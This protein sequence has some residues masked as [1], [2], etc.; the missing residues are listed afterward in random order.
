ML[1]QLALTA[2]LIA[3]GS[4]AGVAQENGPDTRRGDEMIAAY[5]RSETR[6]LAERCLAGIETLEDW[7]SRREEY[8]RQL[9]EMLGLDPMPERTDLKP[10]VT[11]KL[12]HEA[13]TVENLHFQSRPGLY[14]TGN[15]Y[16]P[17]GL[18]KPAPA[19][20]YVCGHAA[21]KKDGVSYGNKTH[22]QFHPAWF[23]RNGYVCLSID[24]IQLGEIEGLHH[25]TYREGMWWWNSRGY[26][27]AGVEA[28]N[29]IRALD[30]LESRPE[31]DA[32]RL[33]ITGRSGGGAYSWWVAALDDRIKA[34]V[35]V[36]GITDLENHV[37][38][39]CVEGHCDCMYMVNTYRWDYAQVAALVA[40]RPLLI[41]NTD[42]DPIF[43]LDG[44]QRIHQ[45]VREIY[46]LY[47]AGDKLGLQI[48]EGP[49]KD[50]QEL[51]VATFHWFNRFLKQ[52]DPPVEQTGLSFFQP[53]QLRVFGDGPPADEI[54]SRIH[55][56]F[57][58]AAA[59]P[60]E[61]PADA[62]SWAALRDAWMAALKEKCF[63]G[64]PEQPAELH[65]EQAFSVQREGIRLTAL[66]FTSQPEIRLRLYLAEPASGVEPSAVVLSVESDRGYSGEFAA[67]CDLFPEEMKEEG[68]GA[69]ALALDELRLQVDKAPMAFFAPRGQGRTRWNQDE[70]KQVQIRRR[71]MLLGQTL[72]AMQA[73]DIR[74]AIQAL[75]SLEQYR[76][77][78]VSIAAGEMPVQAL[79]ASLF[80]PRVAA[81]DFGTL[82][83]THHGA[84]DVLNVRRYLDLPQVVA[85]AAE[86][87]SITLERIEPAGWEYPA[88]VATRLAW[89]A[90]Q[91]S[92][93]EV[94]PEKPEEV[95]P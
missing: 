27:P 63:G 34:A 44:V 70:R 46:R 47:G 60:G 40:P 50:T 22:Y 15:L 91:L 55:E 43:P 16:L 51:Q 81:L 84:A 39:G 10:V 36:A 48:S 54:T 11:G 20:L 87:C 35:P 79:Y 67:L 90:G 5:F 7:T 88:A 26:T 18:D 14:V 59:V 56:T 92:L 52:E 23:A 1:K 29:G 19:V 30:Y 25:G 94:S 62:A 24:T 83:A 89:P 31:V 37:I 85:M 86:R 74:R 71:F 38:D 95:Q 9:A 3:L 77:A 28:W 42:K 21:V 58:Q 45:K 32:E 12:D 93:G 69:G 73:W 72:A 76:E 66:D 4:A 6:L 13:F 49:H 2:A 61:P 41:A 68:Q 75:G 64:W 82:P 17:R 65:V 57:T 80:E 33:G 78:P 53:E 8:R